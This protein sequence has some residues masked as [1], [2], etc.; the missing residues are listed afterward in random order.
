MVMTVENVLSS[1]QSTL[2]ILDSLTGTIAL[3]IVNHS[4]EL[5]NV[6][7]GG[8]RNY[9]GGCI[10][11][12]LDLSSLFPPFPSLP[13]T[14]VFRIPSH[15]TLPSPYF[16]F[17]SPNP[18]Q[19][20]GSGGV[21]LGNFLISTLLCASFNIFSE[22]ENRFLLMSLAKHRGRYVKIIGLAK[23]HPPLP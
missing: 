10:L 12:Y 4:A 13:L 22:K 19:K 16:A 2:K 6:Y 3:S 14:S 11:S 21:I 1:A 9:G 23:P 15:P 8:F 7:S 5:C 18:S 20:R 17:L